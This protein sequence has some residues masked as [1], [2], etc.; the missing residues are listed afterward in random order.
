MS[1]GSR[2]ETIIAL[3]ADLKDSLQGLFDAHARLPEV[4][5]VEHR[6]VENASLAVLE[7]T[8]AEKAALGERIEA[9]VATMRRASTK[10]AEW[11]GYVCSDADAHSAATVTATIGLLRDLHRKLGAADFGAAVLEHEINRLEQLHK[12]FTALHAKISS[13][14]EVNRFVLQKLLAHHQENYRF[15]RKVDEECN[16]TYSAVGQQNAKGSVSLL[17]IKA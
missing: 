1:Q 4:I 14:L 8:A 11:H 2:L 5:E 3:A 16:A 7:K 17:S 10:I 13:S 12:A 15:W 9:C 6:A